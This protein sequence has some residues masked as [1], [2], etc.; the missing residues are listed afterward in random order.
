MRQGSEGLKCYH[1][2]WVTPAGHP[3]LKIAG[4]ARFCEHAVHHAC[5]QL[6]LGPELVAVF[7]D[8]VH[9]IVTAAG[10][11]RRA[12]NT[13]LREAVTRLLRDAHVLPA[14]GGPP[15]EGEGWCATLPNA[16]SAAA[17]RRTLVGRLAGGAYLASAGTGRAAEGLST[18]AATAR[19]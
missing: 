10:L 18:P 12:V 4:A 9:L 5:A 6:G 1:V 15:W 13:Q 19:P 14:A 17:V 3:W 2:I 16:I 7:P 8:R 11:D